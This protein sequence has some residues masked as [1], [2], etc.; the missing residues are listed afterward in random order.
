MRFGFLCFVTVSSALVLSVSGTAGAQPHG[1]GVPIFTIEAQAMLSE[2][3]VL[4]EIAEV[5]G[6][7]VKVTAKETFRGPD[8]RTWDLIWTDTIPTAK[9][10]L[11]CLVFINPA[12]DGRNRDLYAIGC[13]LLDGSNR[14]HEL[15]L[16]Q[17]S[18]RDEILRALRDVRDVTAPLVHVFPEPPSQFQP[19]PVIIVPK[20]RRLE[21]LA[22]EWLRSPDERWQ[23]TGLSAISHFRSPE[24]L[25]RLKAI[26]SDTRFEEGYGGGRWKS[27]T[28]VKREQALSVVTLWEE[29]IGKASTVGPVVFHQPVPKKVTAWVVGALAVWIVVFAIV[30]GFWRRRAGMPFRIGAFLGDAVMAILLAAVLLVGWL[31]RR[32]QRVVDEVVFGIGRTHHE[33]ASYRG[34]VQYVLVQDWEWD[35]RFRYGLFEPTKPMELLNP[36]IPRRF[37]PARAVPFPRRV[38][39]MWQSNVAHYRY[40]HELP[41]EDAW[42]LNAYAFTTNGRKWG[43]R[44]GTGSEQ[45]HHGAMLKYKVVRIPYTWI[46]PVVALVPLMR[47]PVWVRRWTRLRKGLCPRCGYDV[48]VTP[49]ACPECGWRRKIKRVPSPSAAAA[50]PHAQSV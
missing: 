16:R 10:G 33:I 8:K 41:K 43:V 30:R 24:N 3:V 36:I 19:S 50:M 46:L 23:W 26:L 32:S 39:P 31:W 21:V 14:V 37:P 49:D 2:V 38:P 4:G 22:H 7:R 20:L 5:D 12:D 17:I 48:R 11:E 18:G 40:G 1:T 44:W 27:G 25:E 34:G 9:V 35:E 15:S 42:D 6:A 29:P 28:Y 45:M 13:I 47:L